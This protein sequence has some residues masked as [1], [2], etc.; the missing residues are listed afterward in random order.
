MAPESGSQ[1]SN[2]SSEDRWR[3]WL[4]PAA[5]WFFEEAAACAAAGLD[6]DHR[7]VTPVTQAG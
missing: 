5:P 3:K 6:E 4:R 7:A 2:S 1:T